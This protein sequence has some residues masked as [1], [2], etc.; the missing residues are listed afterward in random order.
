LRFYSSVV[1][2]AFLNRMKEDLI[3]RVTASVLSTK[4]FTDLV[5]ALCRVS[6]LDEETTYVKRK[7]EVLGIRPKDVGIS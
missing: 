6:T 1:D 3:E 4:K 5:I 2:W 7:L